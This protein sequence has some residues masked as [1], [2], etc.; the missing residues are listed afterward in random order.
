VLTAEKEARIFIRAAIQND[1]DKPMASRLIGKLVKAV[2]SDE[3]EDCANTG[4]K[5]TVKYFGDEN[6]MF[7]AKIAATIRAKK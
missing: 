5:E 4:Y 7:A 2:R 3:R 6:V 1:C